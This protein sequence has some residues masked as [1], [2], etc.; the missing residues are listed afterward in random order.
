MTRIPDL[1]GLSSVQAT[2]VLKENGLSVGSIIEQENPN[3]DIGLVLDQD[4]KVDMWVAR[5]STV[6]LVVASESKNVVVPSVGNM[7]GDEAKKTLTQAR[8]TIEEIPTY[9]SAIAV[10]DVVGQLP[11]SDTLVQAGSTVC[12]LVSQGSAGVSIPTPRVMGLT[13]ENAE[14]VLRDMG[15]APLPYHA[16]TTFGRTGEVVAQTPATGVLTYPGSPVQY[17]VSDNITGADSIVPDTVGMREE[18][19]KLI[20]QEAGF[21]VNMYP[22]V[23]NEAPQGTVVAQMPLARD[24]LVRKGDTIDLLVSCGNEVRALVPDVLDEKLGSARE[25]LR[26]QGFTPVVVSLPGSAKEGTVSQQFPARGSD[27]YL[28]LPVLLYAGERI[29]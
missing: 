5:G 28:G 17:L 14:R 29:R 27:Y 11:M 22:Y 15:F 3:V 8:L 18:N 21:K 4:P 10:G 20:I 9:D 24:T 19:A 1:I 16:T 23:D 13:A 25:A 26:K 12:V 7:T 2:A 6:T